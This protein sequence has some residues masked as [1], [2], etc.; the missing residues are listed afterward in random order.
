MSTTTNLADFGF[1]EI[2]MARDLLDA[3]VNNGLPDDFGDNGVHLMMNQNSGNVFLTNEEFEVA[4]LNGDTLESFYTSPY[5]GREGFFE[6]LID[7]YEDMHEEDKEWLRNIAENRDELDKL[8]R[9]FEYFINKDERGEFN[10]D[11][12]DKDGNTVFEIEGY[13]VFEDGFMSDK[14]DLDGLKDHLVD[15]GLMKEEDELKEGN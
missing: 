9:T 5:E 3:W 4:M 2:K 12:R 6:D 10:A 14:N 7:E 11:V 15:C 1:R 8:V 13:D